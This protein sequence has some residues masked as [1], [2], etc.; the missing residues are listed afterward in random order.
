MA[1]KFYPLPWGHAEV[2]VDRVRRAAPVLGPWRGIGGTG[3]FPHG[4]S[5]SYR[6]KRHEARN[7]RDTRPA[8]ARHPGPV[9]PSTSR[10]SRARR[11]SS[12]STAPEVE[13][14]A[15][16]EIRPRRDGHELI[17]VIEERGR[18]VP[19]GAGRGSPPRDHASGSR[20]RGLD[21]LGRPRRARRLRRAARSN[22]ASG[23]VEFEHVGG[24]A[25]INSAS[26]DVKLTHVG[27]QL[28][29][30]TASGDLEVGRLIG[31]G[32]VRAASGDISIDEADRRL[33][34]QT[35]SGD[36][37][38][39]SVRQGDV[40]LQ[41]ASGDIDVAVKQGS[42]VFIDA[43]SMSGE[44]SYRARD[45]RRSVRRRGPAGRDQRH[46]HE[47]GHRYPPGL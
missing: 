23:D 8:H 29:V 3:R 2:R 18:P 25:Q 31:E 32:K 13:E 17:V 28:S 9:G 15:R 47:R 26:G 5:T 14:E 44:T 43:R 40:T 6:R 7:I 35:A 33:K 22:T 20:R 45:H 46:R 24:E 16:I 11:P 41:T 30:N 27:G 10:L 36:V 42:K 12:S 4:I 19:S 39:R 38:V 37:D 34:V 1:T 21:G